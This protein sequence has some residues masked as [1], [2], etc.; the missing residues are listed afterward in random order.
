MLTKAVGL[1]ATDIGARLRPQQSALALAQPRLLKEFSGAKQH[2]GA[3]I[4]SPF[5]LS[6]SK[7]III[8]SKLLV[9]YSPM[10]PA[11]FG[12]KSGRKSISCVYTSHELTWFIPYHSSCRRADPHAHFRIAEEVALRVLLR[13]FAQICRMSHLP[14]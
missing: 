7:I 14:T 3:S 4:I 6:L 5:S 12:Q 2:M 13:N 1:A 8:I 9:D 10:D 11:D